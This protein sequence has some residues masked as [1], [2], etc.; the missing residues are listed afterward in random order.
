M[1]YLIRDV[2]SAP[3]VTI[4]ASAALVDAALLL[5]GNSMR[6]LP[7]VHD[8]K[9]V[10]LI[11]DRDIQ[12]CAPSLLIPVTEETYNS[13]FSDTKVERV[14]I[15]DPQCVSSSEPLSAAIVRMQEAKCGCLPVVDSGVLVGILTRGDLLDVLQRLLAGKS[16]SRS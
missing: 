2:M 6:H 4:D 5:R 12:R 9:L 3:V 13:V 1:E 7:V 14:M 16:A 15:R 10:G 8:G 11:S